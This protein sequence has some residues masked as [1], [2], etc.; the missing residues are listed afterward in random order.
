[1]L[2]P[3]V[4]VLLVLLLQLTCLQWLTSACIAAMQDGTTALVASARKQS[5]ECIR[6]L[7]ATGGID[8]NA[9][10]VVRCHVVSANV[11]SARACRIDSLPP[12]DSP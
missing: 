2:A 5:V 10:A 12:G 7:L 6:A 3:L 9:C 11:V 8:A 4:H 1:M